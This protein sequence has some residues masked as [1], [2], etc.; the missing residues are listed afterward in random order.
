MNDLKKTDHS[1]YVRHT[2][3]SA[4]L[5]IDVNS[6]NRYREERS[7]ILKMDQLAKEVQSMKDDMNDIKAL[8]Q[9]LVNG[10]TNG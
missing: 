7:R 8:L 3:S 1:E 9:Q 5:N 10:K 6:F 2:D 4:I